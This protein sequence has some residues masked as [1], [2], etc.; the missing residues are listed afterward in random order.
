MEE[1][2]K[3][4]REWVSDYRYN[5]SNKIPEDIR[6]FHERFAIKDE[7]AEEEVKVAK[8]GKDNQKK[9]VKVVKKDDKK[10]EV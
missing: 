8:K 2:L 3:E 10:K 9:N 4:R 5:N 7:G 1:M 6:G